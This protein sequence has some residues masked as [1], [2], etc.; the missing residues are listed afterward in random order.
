MRFYHG[1]KPAAQAREECR[2]FAPRE[3]F[4]SRSEQNTLDSSRMPIR[5]NKKTVTL[6][7]ML[8]RLTRDPKRPTCNSV[9][10]ESIPRFA[11]RYRDSSIRTQHSACDCGATIESEHGPSCESLCRARPFRWLAREP[12]HLVV[13]RRNPGRLQ[14]RILQGQR[15][16][17][18]RH[19][20]RP[21]RRAPAGSQP[22]WRRDVDDRKPGRARRADSRGQGA[23]RHHAAG[24]QG[25]A[26]AGLSRRHR[27]HAI[28]ISP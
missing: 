14:R 6:M 16:R 23:A 19:R 22:R 12:W 24:A 13:G 26:V 28:R 3:E 21:A 25:A 1:S 4:C 10:L 27:L 9:R 17:S 11:M 18:A 2:P 15:S 8:N 5:Q 20:S 7:R